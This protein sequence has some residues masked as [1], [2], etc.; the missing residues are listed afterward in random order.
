VKTIVF[1]LVSCLM[2]GREDGLNRLGRAIDKVARY[3]VFVGNEQRLVFRNRSLSLRDANSTVLRDEFPTG[4]VYDVGANNGDDTEYYLKKGFRVVAIEANPT[5]ANHIRTRFAGAL[6]NRRLEVVNIAVGDGDYKSRLY[7]NSRDSKLSTLVKPFHYD[8]Q[9]TDI[10]IDVTR[11]STIVK[12][13]GRPAHVKLD[14]EGADVAVLREMFSAECFPESISAEAHSIE[15]LCLF[16]AAGYQNF[17][18]VEGKFVHSRF[19]TIRTVNGSLL[20][21]NFPEG[22]CAG[23]F[24]NDLPGNR[25]GSEEVFRY[26]C[27]HGLGWKDIHAFRN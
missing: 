20:E 9:W 21:H 11:L 6:Q 5:L 15:V 8:E 25:M 4:I 1:N 7:V 12:E 17:K 19:R 24:G 16:V 27:E 2:R 18:I 23:P 10:E 13:H 3:I 14:I 22:T 26:L